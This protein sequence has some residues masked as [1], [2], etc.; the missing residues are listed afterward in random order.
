MRSQTQSFDQEETNSKRSSCWRKP[1]LFN[2]NK[3]LD[4]NQL[5]T[6]EAIA[7]RKALFA[8]FK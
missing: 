4:L 3:V 1:K 7:A 5:E 8:K 6:E 2:T